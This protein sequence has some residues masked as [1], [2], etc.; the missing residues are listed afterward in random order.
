MS[1][2]LAYY[3]DWQGLEDFS[4]YPFDPDGLPQVRHPGVKRLYHNAITIAQFGL[5][6][7]QKYHA[8]GQEKDRCKALASA[9]WLAKNAREWHHGILAWIYD[10][11]FDF[12][13]PPAPWISAMAQGEGISLLLRAHQLEPS[14]DWLQIAKGAMH[15]FQYPVSAGGVC[16]H[17]P[18]GSIIFEEY[19]TQPPS[20]VLNGHVFALLG[21]YDFAEFSGEP[22]ARQLLEKGLSA[23]R[24]NWGKWDT[25]FWTRYDLHPTR[26]L[27][28]RMYQKVHVRQ[29]ATL[30]RL[31]DDQLLINVAKRWQRMLR[32]PLNN[33]FWILAKGIEKVRLRR[34]W[35]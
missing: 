3:F 12:Y 16:E 22:G 34:G 25:G 7:L 28:S 11:E 24:N 29:M 1:L 31:F 15:A 21:V 8:A 13:G 18:D 32:N 20:H 14:E 35:R 17:F 10:I 30:G 4:A 6:C 2:P 19:P 27:A 23:I 5:S 26:R 9:A 33:S